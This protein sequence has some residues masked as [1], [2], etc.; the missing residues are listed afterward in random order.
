MLIQRHLL[1]SSIILKRG[2]TAENAQNMKPLHFCMP[3]T[4][5][6]KHLFLVGVFYVSVYKFSVMSGR[7]K[8][9]NTQHSRPVETRTSDPSVSS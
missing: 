2:T 9:L 3:F 1:Y 8:G 7:F 4:V 5:N 6:L